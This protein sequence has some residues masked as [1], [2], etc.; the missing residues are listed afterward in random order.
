[1]LRPHFFVPVLIVDAGARGVGKS[2][3]GT[4][5]EVNGS[6]CFGYDRM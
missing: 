5:C 2:V 1:M 4:C 6:P 3:S